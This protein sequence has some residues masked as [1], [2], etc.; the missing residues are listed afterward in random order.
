[1][2]TR[3]AAV[4]TVGCLFLF[5]PRGA[6][7]QAR[8]AE[9]EA[10]D[11]YQAGATAYE[12]GRFED[13]AR[14][15]RRAYLLSG[16]AA[17]LYNVGQA[18]L[19]LGR[20]ALALEAFEGY[21]RQSDDSGER[22]SEVEERV[23]V[24]RSL[25]VRPATE[26]EV[27]EAARAAQE[28]SGSPSAPAPSRGGS[29]FAPWIVVGVGAAVAVAGAVLLGVAASEA[30]RFENAPDG[31]SWEEYERIASDAQA[32]WLG[33]WI[34]LGVG[35]AAAVAGVAWALASGG[36]NSATAELRVGPAGISLAGTF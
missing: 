30:S 4:L 29:D 9:D 11:H 26:S 7:A 33:G 10:R 19:R 12:A 27:A 15:F 17:L 6:G 36:S 20:D 28:S 3:I 8:S 24:L 18:E 31:S 25:G 32:M 1:M 5:A 2:R 22:R 16:R 13:A 14:A 21:L 23:R 35:A 34:A